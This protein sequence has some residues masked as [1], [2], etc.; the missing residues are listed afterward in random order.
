MALKTFK[1]VD[2]KICEMNILLLFIIVFLSIF[3]K[4]PQGL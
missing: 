1:Q 2:F 3:A 4:N